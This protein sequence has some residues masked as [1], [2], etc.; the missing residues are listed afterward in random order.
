MS[1][2]ENKLNNLKKALQ[3]FKK[4]D[5]KDCTCKSEHGLEKRCWEGY[6]PTPGKKAYSDDSCRPI[7]KKES[8]SKNMQKSEAISYLAN[9]QWFLEKSKY[10][11]YDPND[12]ARRKAN[13]LA[14]EESPMQAMSRVKAYGGG[15]PNALKRQVQELKR[16]SR[17]SPT[18]SYKKE[19]YSP[20]EWSK[21]TGQKVSESAAPVITPAAALT[22]DNVVQ[23]P[24]AKPD[25]KKAA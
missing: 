18:K 12:N 17:K 9:G 20:E 11:G 1:S 16:K 5:K 10:S 2:L 13:N 25:E 23:L 22:T 19:D 21:L 15:G 3:Q 7:K 24:Q 6:E 4:S 8:D 14:G